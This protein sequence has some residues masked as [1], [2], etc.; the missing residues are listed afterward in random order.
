[1]ILHFTLYLT[2]NILH[3]YTIYIFANYF[4]SINRVYYFL[5]IKGLTF[6]NALSIEYS[7]VRTTIIYN[8]LLFLSTLWE[9]LN[10]GSKSTN[11]GLIRTFGRI[12]LSS[13][14]YC[15]TCNISVPLYRLIFFE[16]CKIVLIFSFFINNP[17]IKVLLWY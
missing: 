12:K 13:I 17:V 4:C 9:K 8:V 11:R 5:C 7:C 1:M 10:I 16:K 3:S 2:F 14:S 15:V 6:G